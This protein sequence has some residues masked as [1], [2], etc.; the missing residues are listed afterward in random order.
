MM[1]RWIG[2]AL[3]LGLCAHVSMAGSSGQKQGAGAWMD[4]F[5]VQKSELASRGRNRYFILEPGYR[6]TL[7]HGS[8]RLVVSVLNE[9]EKVDGVETRVVE[10]RETKGGHLAE[11]SRNFF[12]IHKRTG[13]LY[14]FGEGVDIYKSD[15]IVNHEG[16]ASR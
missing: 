6:S 9:T 2:A 10:E 14:Y 5:E 13:D 4:R 7:E 12:A 16:G 1:S 3:V 11:V 8:E 15:K